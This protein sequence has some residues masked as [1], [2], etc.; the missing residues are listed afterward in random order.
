MEAIEYGVME[1]LELAVKRGGY[2]NDHITMLRPKFIIIFSIKTH[3]SVSCGQVKPARHT[4][5]ILTG[6]T[7]TGLSRIRSSVLPC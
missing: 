4:V 7:K 2:V 6:R 3:G 5:S 1:L